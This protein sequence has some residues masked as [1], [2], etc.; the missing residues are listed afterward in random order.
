MLNQNPLPWYTPPSIPFLESHLNSDHVVLDVGSGNSTLWYAK[1]TKFVHAIETEVNWYEEIK[2]NQPNNVQLD[3]KTRAGIIEALTNPIMDY[4]VISIDP[5]ERESSM[6]DTVTSRKCMLDLAVNNFDN[7][8]VYV[9]DNWG[10]KYWFHDIHDFTGDQMK[11]YYPKL[12]DY[13]VYDF[14][15][16]GWMGLGTRLLIKA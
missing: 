12:K 11:E 10:E 14:F 1:Q 13:V 9:L 4:N 3:F 5:M 7:V 16:G 15:Q 6:G 2:N 8:D